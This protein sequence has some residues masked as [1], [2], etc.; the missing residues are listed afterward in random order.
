[1]DNRQNKLINDSLDNEFEYDLNVDKKKTKNND[2][3]GVEPLRFGHSSQ[4]GNLGKHDKIDQPK[5]FRRM[6]F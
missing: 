2:E 3:G 6:S 1:M 4:L 5:N